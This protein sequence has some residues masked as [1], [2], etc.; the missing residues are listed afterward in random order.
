MGRREYLPLAQRHRSQDDSDE[1]SK[2]LLSP[3]SK[4]DQ[5]F[6]HIEHDDRIVPLAELI[7]NR[8]IQIAILNYSF[9]ALVCLTR[10]L[11][12]PRSSAE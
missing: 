9:M 5:T 1:D 4:Q 10:N 7:Q 2:S 8:T 11:S 3:T 12:T 6:D